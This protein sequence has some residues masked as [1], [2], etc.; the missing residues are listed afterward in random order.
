[1]PET[2]TKFTGASVEDYIASRANEQQHSDCRELMVLLKKITRR[3][4]KMWGPS[5]VG[6]GVYRYTYESGH[7]GEAPLTGFAIRGRELV[8]YLLAE[9][10]RQ[11]RLLSRLGKHRMCKSCLYFKRLADVDTSVLEQLVANSVADVK[12][13]YG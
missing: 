2:K 7:T 9:E 11:K 6:Y 10:D 1:M 3:P 5:I 8:V 4:P 12:R 13:R